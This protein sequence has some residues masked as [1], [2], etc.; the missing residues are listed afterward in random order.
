MNRHI[1]LEYEDL[2]HMKGKQKK[3][4]SKHEKAFGKEKISRERSKSRQL[5]KRLLDPDYDY[6]EEYD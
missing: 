1:F 5:K 2:T 3:T 6:E 4:I